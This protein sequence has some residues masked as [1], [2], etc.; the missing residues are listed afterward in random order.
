MRLIVSCF[1]SLMLLVNT[2]FAKISLPNAN[3]L[4]NNSDKS[5]INTLDT[6]LGPGLNTILLAV[7]KVGYAVAII[8]TV[9]IAIKLLL[10]TPAKKAEVK[11]AIM[12]YLIGLL[13]LIAGVP[14]AIKVI[15]IYTG[16]F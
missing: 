2:C 5:F 6:S 3:N 14:I 7:Y 11:A 16:I 12:P 4:F 8:A 10:T 15:E 1:V 9:I 13:L